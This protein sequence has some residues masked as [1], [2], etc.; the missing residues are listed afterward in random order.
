MASIPLFLGQEYLDIHF[1][2]FLIHHDFLCSIPGSRS[3]ASRVGVGNSEDLC[4]STIEL[5]NVD[6]YLLVLLQF[7]RRANAPDSILGYRSS[8]R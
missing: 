2:S 3:L 5:W 4:Q 8:D 1:W 7:S 6:F